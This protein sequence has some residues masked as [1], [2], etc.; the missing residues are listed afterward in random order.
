MIESQSIEREGLYN[1]F[2]K[3]K[4]YQKSYILGPT[5]WE[6]TDLSRLQRYVV[7]TAFK[8]RHTPDDEFIYGFGSAQ[9]DLSR[10]GIVKTWFAI[11]AALSNQSNWF[12]IWRQ[13]ISYRHW[14][15]RMTFR[16]SEDAH[17]DVLAGKRRQVHPSLFLQEIGFVVG[18]CIALGWFDWAEKLSSL[19]RAAMDRDNK[20]LNLLFNDAG[21]RFGRRRT[22]HFV[23][24]LVADWK[25]WAPPVRP[26]C[27]FD[28]PIF[29]ALVE[30]WKTPFMEEISHLLLAA[31][32]R[33]THQ[34]RGDSFSR[35]A[36]YDLPNHDFWYAPFE[37][38]SVL[39]LRELLNLQ[40]PN[41]EHPLLA[42][43]LGLLPPISDQYSDP[44]LDG[45]LVQ[46]RRERSEF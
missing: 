22:Q 43:P 3:A 1:R 30:S 21:D 7:E 35:G 12:D 36:F 9:A 17:R 5:D 11:Q 39:R 19:T 4:S 23:L 10:L 42:T 34:S 18:Q 16:M 29:N 2:P 37:I 8:Y 40:N 6:A 24:R 45:V 33:H 15:L 46:A 31:C 13:A 26:L 20:E 32:D 14:A 27:A 25:G 28:T 44:L 41:L 38:L